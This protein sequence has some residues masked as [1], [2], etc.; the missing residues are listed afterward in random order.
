MTLVK[1]FLSSIFNT[2]AGAVLVLACPLA[3][4]YYVFPDSWRRALPVSIYFLGV[5]GLILA[6]FVGSH[7]MGR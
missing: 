4:Y 6:V 2:E 5:M 3:L 7:T 1:V